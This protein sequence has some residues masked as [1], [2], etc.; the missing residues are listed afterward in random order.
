ME[1]ITRREQWLRPGGR[2]SRRMQCLMVRYLLFVTPPVV[3]HLTVPALHT[4]MRALVGLAG[5]AAILVGIRIHR[6]AE[7]WP[8]LL[9]AAANPTFTAG[10]TTYNL[11][12]AAF[13]Q[14]PLQLRG[15]W[16]AGTVMDLGWVL[17][18]SRPGGSPRCTRHA[19]AQPDRVLGVRR[20]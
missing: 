11:R 12:E 4:A 13:G 9:L 19:A 18:S 20:T 10:D 16:Q 8:W 5:V 6:P 17:C 14:S 2:S 1:T 15:T 3:I 7:R